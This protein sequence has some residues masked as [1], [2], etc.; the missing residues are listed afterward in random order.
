LNGIS[1][2]SSS[3]TSIAVDTDSGS[4]GT[5]SSSSSTSN[6]FFAICTRRGVV[7]CEVFVGLGVRALSA[8]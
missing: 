1:S 8:R 6:G 7:K 3:T 5:I 2:F 4:E